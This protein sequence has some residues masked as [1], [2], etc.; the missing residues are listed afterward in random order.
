MKI[1]LSRSMYFYHA[2]ITFL[3]VCL[4][5]F[6]MAGCIHAAESST[7]ETD[8]APKSDTFLAVSAGYDAK[9]FDIYKVHIMGSEWGIEGGWGGLG[10]Q[11]IAD[12]ESMK[13]YAE[14]GMKI[15]SK[16]NVYTLGI[17]KRFKFAY[18][19][20][21]Y[22]WMNLTQDFKRS[23]SGGNYATLKGNL[24]AAT[25]DGFGGL[26]DKVGFFFYDVRVGYRF[27]VSSKYE[28]TS[29]AGGGS[30]SATINFRTDNINIL[31]GAFGSVSIGIA[32]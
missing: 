14:S 31:E 13:V 6:F 27:G 10:I 29:T 12:D 30:G 26:S 22:T 11:G 19:G 2:I 15:E 16:V 17:L 4:C 5:Q 28:V 23:G 9:A 25:V 8:V 7:P 24:D 18:I 1:K 21:G 32:F 3:M 20:L